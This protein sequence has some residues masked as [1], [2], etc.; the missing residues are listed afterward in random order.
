MSNSTLKNVSINIVKSLGF[1]F[2]LLLLLSGPQVFGSTNKKNYDKYRL[3][4]GIPVPNTKVPLVNNTVFDQLQATV[5]NDVGS[6][7][8][9]CLGQ[10]EDIGNLVDSNFNNFSNI[11]ITGIGCNAILSVK[12]ANDTYVAGTYA[13]FRI[14]TEGLLRVSLGASV[15]IRTY[16]NGTLRETYNAVNSL[17]SI[18]SNLLNADGTATIGFITSSPFDEIRIEYTSLLLDVLSNYRVY[19]AIIQQFSAP[20]STDFEC[21]TKTDWSNPDFPV[22]ISAANTGFLTGICVGCSISNIDNVIS[23]STSDFASLSMVA[24]IGNK[25]AVAVKDVITNYTAGTFAGF[26]VSSA[27]LLQASIG[28]TV[29]I[30]TYLDG[31][32]Q[33]TYPAITSSIGI[34]SSLIDGNGNAILGFVTT[35][36]FDEI[37]IE[38]TSLLNV[39]F[40]SQIYGAVVEKFCDGD[41]LACNT[42]T[43]LINPDFPVVISNENTGVGGVLNIGS[44]VNNA[45]NLISESETDFATLNLAAGVLNSNVAIAVQNVLGSYPVGTY[46]GFN[47]AT[48]SLLNV[49]LLGGFSIKTYNN[50]N[51]A[52]TFSGQS[53]LATVGSSLLTGS[54]RYSIGVVATEEFDEI[55]L[56]AG[57][58]I[59]GV[60]LGTINVYNAFVKRVCT[61]PIECDATYYLNDGV[62]GFPVIV[63]SEN[64]GI[65]GIACV[66]CSVNDTQNVISSDINDYATINTTVNALGR[67]SIAVKDILNTF[68]IGSVAG[69]AIQDT[70]GLVALDLLSSLQISTYLYGV[71]QESATDGDLLNLTVI[72]DIFGSSAGRYNVGFK[73]T[74]R[75]DEIKI[76]SAAVASVLNSIRVYGAFIDTKTANDALLGFTC[77]SAPIAVDDSA[78]ATTEVLYSSTATL[79]SNDTDA[80]GDT[81]TVTAGTFTTAE[82]GEIIIAADG[83]YTYQSATG[84]I[85]TDSYVYTVGDGQATATGTVMFTVNAQ[86]NSA[87][88]AVDDSATATSE[89]LYNSTATLQANDTD[90]DGDTLTV[91]AGTFATVEGGEIIIAADGSYTYQSATGFVGTDSYVYTVGDGQATATG[92]VTFTVNAPVN[93]SP[94]AVDDS[95]TVTSEVLYSSTATL[96]SNDTDADGDILTV[97]AGT[98]TTAEG[99]EI[100]IAADGN[101]TYQSA[102]GFVGTDSYVYTVGDGQAT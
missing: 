79:Q 14:G 29:D 8:P 48:S 5:L 55:R 18:N 34:N 85:G 3:N 88:V 87:P 38:Y 47:I 56:I 31:V 52:E 26:K 33:E 13:G 51:E 96:Q 11:S 12:D 36:E 41:D 22:A 2:V 80:D 32:E 23:E 68:P 63:N 46:A 39:L 86:L 58:P 59:A 54:N 65:G 69:F 25:G 6:L 4:P 71:L 60:N 40:S 92:T 44:S 76:S 66:G 16:D 83:S 62:N 17:V 15:Q 21:N 28:A 64:T 74:K 77:N 57:N 94:V 90:A 89:V 78:T 93:S 10:V 100:I 102:T 20:S 72:A 67:P 101:Y 70:N 75:F 84:F 53:I 45:E 99:G 42:E 30:V 27:G 37:K 61:Q 1:A 19:N 97:T 95:A 91:T 35:K 50:G 43:S 81:L 9:L 82:G 73:T 98:F 49:G 24:G 7:T